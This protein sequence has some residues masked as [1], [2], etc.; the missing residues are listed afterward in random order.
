MCDVLSLFQKMKAQ[1]R[2]LDRRLEKRG[3]V[4]G[5]EEKKAKRN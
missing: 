3:N 2:G 1:F 4:E 5:K